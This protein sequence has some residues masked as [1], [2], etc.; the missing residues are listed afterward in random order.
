ML[1]PVRKTTRATLLKMFILDEQGGYGG[2]YVLDDDCLIE[3]GDFLRVVPESGLADEDSVYLAEYQATAFHGNRLSLIA[4]SRGPLAPED[5]AWTK[6]ALVATEAHFTNADSARTPTTEPDRGVMESLVS[7]L[8]KREADLVA[9]EKAL[10]ESSNQVRE[11]AQK[12]RSN[13]EAEVLALQGRIKDTETKREQER[14]QFD[15]ERNR[16]RKEADSAAPKAKEASTLPVEREQL[17][18]ERKALQDQTSNLQE[19]EKELR[20]R[21]A[22]LAQKSEDVQ[23]IGK[24]N[25]T[26]RAKIEELKKSPPKEFDVEAARREID[27]RVKILQQKALDLLDREEKLRRRAEELRQ[28]TDGKS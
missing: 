7:A 6:A 17:E 27:M 13:L 21:E 9:R 14:R 20:T 26:L 15:D 4:I 19:R 8:E 12:A 25:E 18:R 5:L 28:A 3:Y 22:E 23:A 11:E 24:E 16:L 2:E 10:T 1:Q